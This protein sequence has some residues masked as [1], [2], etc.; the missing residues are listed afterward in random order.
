LLPLRLLLA[1]GLLNHICGLHPSDAVPT[2]PTL[3]ICSPLVP[4]TTGIVIGHKPLSHGALLELIDRRD[5]E[6]SVAGIGRNDRVAIVLNNGPEMAACFMAC[7]SSATTNAPLNPAYR[8]DEFEFYLADA[9]AKALIVNPATHQPLRWPPS[10]ATIDDLVVTDGTPAGRFHIGG[11]RRPK[12]ARHCPCWFCPAR[13]RVDGALHTSV[14]PHARP[15]IVPL[16]Q[17]V[18]TPQPLTFWLR[19]TAPTLWPR[20]YQYRCSTSIGLIAGVLAPPCRLSWCSAPGFSSAG[21]L[22]D[23]RRLLTWYTAVP[24]MHQAIVPSGVENTVIARS[25][26]SCAHR[27]RRCLRR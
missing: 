12:I 4:T 13:R 3:K 22:T 8:A 11:A 23:G 15:K 2:I 10:W 16:S 25:C 1:L 9:D 24:T 5:A 6:P 21:S 18:L 7:A 20:V 17:P 26:A 19:F 27:R 14:P